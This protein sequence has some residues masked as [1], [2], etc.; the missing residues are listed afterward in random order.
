MGSGGG[1]VETEESPPRK[2]ETLAG[3]D[4]GGEEVGEGCVGIAEKAQCPV[5]QVQHT[6]YKMRIGACGAGEHGESEM[7]IKKDVEVPAAPPMTERTM[8]E[9]AGRY[10]R[11]SRSVEGSRHG[12]TEEKSEDLESMGDEGNVLSRKKEEARGERTQKRGSCSDDGRK[13]GSRDGRRETA[14]MPEGKKTNK[15]GWTVSADDSRGGQLPGGSALASQIAGRQENGVPRRKGQSD[16]RYIGD[17]SALACKPF[18]RREEDT[19][20]HEKPLTVDPRI[21]NERAPGE[22]D[23]GTR[24]LRQ[25]ERDSVSAASPSFVLAREQELLVFPPLWGG[26]ET[27]EDQRDRRLFRGRS[28]ESK[29]VSVTEG[30]N[31]SGQK[32]GG[33]QSRE[34]RQGSGETPTEGAQTERRSRQMGK[35]QLSLLS[36]K[37]DKMDTFRG[38]ASPAPSSSS[39]FESDSLIALEKRNSVLSSSQVLPHE[40]QPS[41]PPR[42]AGCGPGKRGLPRSWGVVVL[43]GSDR[44]GKDKGSQP[45]PPLDMRRK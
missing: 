42:A 33:E 16:D 32:E 11:V 18:E 6:P 17:T 30:R 4:R 40:P 45:P 38:L 7:K 44:Q 29:F 5:G 43:L 28:R 14:L 22:D 8:L 37:E 34:K 10:A 24:R 27:E 26:Q 23:P 36:K 15:H 35:R 21:E 9:E 41:S 12:M 1:D 19:D 25:E 31:V 2:L 13:A 20:M 39:V 3:R